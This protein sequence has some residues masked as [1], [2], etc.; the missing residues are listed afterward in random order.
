M[1][2][3]NWLLN[4]TVNKTTKESI[5]IHKQAEL[6][7]PH[8]QNQIFNYNSMILQLTIVCMNMSLILNLIQFKSIKNNILHKN[9]DSNSKKLGISLLK[10]KTHENIKFIIEHHSKL[11]IQIK[12]K[13]LSFGFVFWHQIK[14]GQAKPQ[15]VFW[16]RQNK[17]THTCEKH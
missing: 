16:F 5:I 7:K 11:N 10:K 8:F 1:K 4:I 14:S 17:W 2:I 12:N 3:W 15:K 13:F 6:N 9:I